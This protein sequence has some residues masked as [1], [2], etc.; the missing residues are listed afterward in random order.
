MLQCY[1]L[2]ILRSQNGLILM[3]A[4]LYET[5][6]CCRVLNLVNTDSTQVQRYFLSTKNYVTNKA[7]WASTLPWQRIQALFFHKYGHV[8]PYGFTLVSAGLASSKPD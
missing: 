2:H 6:K 1:P 3:I 8:F 4:W 5:E 7:L